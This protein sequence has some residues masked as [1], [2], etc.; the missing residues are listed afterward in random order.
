MINGTY[1]LG[2]KK[3]DLEK[4]FSS[5]KKINFHKIFKK[6][7]I[8]FIHRTSKKENSHTLA[9]EVGKKNLKNIKEKVES[10][11]FLTQSPVSTIPSS[12]SLLH[13][14]LKLSENCYV[15]DVIQGC[16]SFPYAFNLVI[17]LIKNKEFNNSLIICSETYTK[18]ILNNDKIC[19]PIFS[20]AASS[21]FFNKETMPNLLSSIYLTDG[22]G[23]KN[24]CVNKKGEL[25]MNGVEVFS[26]TSEKVPYAVNEL[27]KKANLQIKDISYF[28]FHQ[29]SKIVLD[30][31][32]QKLQI[33]KEKFYNKIELIGNTVSS[34]IPIGLIES[35]KNKKILKG[36]PFLL[37]GFGVG[38][39]LSGGIYKFD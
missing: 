29:A 30:T 21:L 19:L 34:T 11:I 25:F 17:N 1:K 36:K 26:F 6:T 27:L 13:N 38:Y 14:D 20:D 31:I 23:H 10:L 28:I 8:R 2:S 22:R 12:G 4:N 32:Q 15:L 9:C 3:I 18:N 5:S 33:P 39:S 35:F 37:M 7:G 16:S 24:L